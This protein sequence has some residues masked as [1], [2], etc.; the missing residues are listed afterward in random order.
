M[1]LSF[2]FSNSQVSAKQHQAWSNTSHTLD[3]KKEWGMCMH[4]QAKIECSVNIIPMTPFNKNNTPQTPTP[5]PAGF[6][7]CF[8]LFFSTQRTKPGGP[9][10]CLWGGAGQGWGRWVQQ[11]RVCVFPTFLRCVNLKNI[12]VLPFKSEKVTFW[13]SFKLDMTV[14]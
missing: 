1:N 5:F 14:H 11:W 12:Y 7:F 8:I 4:T 6:L 3:I 13:T 9:H 10:V 2:Y